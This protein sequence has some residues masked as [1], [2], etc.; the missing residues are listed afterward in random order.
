MCQ[1]LKRNKRYYSKLPA[2]QAGTKSSD[3]LCIDLIGKYR[4]TSNRGGRKYATRGEK[5]KDVYLQAI[6]M[7]DLATG[8]KHICSVPE[9]RADPVANQVELSW[10]TRYPLPN[11]ITID[12]GTEL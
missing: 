12:G 4:M 6:T 7:I 2:K 5:D 11:K 3:M 1:F 9:A 8:W 10:L